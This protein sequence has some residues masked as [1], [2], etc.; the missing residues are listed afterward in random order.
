[1]TTGLRT[2]TADGVLTIRLD[3]AEKRNALTAD[4][5]GGIAEALAQAELDAAVRVVALR[6]EGKDFCAG[7]DLAELL[8][9]AQHSLDEN[10]RDA[11]ALGEV[12]LAMRRLPK[13]VVA[14]VQG[15]AVAGGAG[16][17][18]AADLV[19][20]ARSASFG[21]PEIERGFVPAMVMT[22]LRRSVGEKRAFE[23]VSTGRLV[24]AD[25]ALGLGLVSRVVDD[26]GLEDAARALL[27]QLTARSAT[28]LALTKQLFTDLDGRDVA[29]GILL[30][31]RV[32]ALSR[33]TDDFKR[34]VA[35][36]LDR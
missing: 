8:A 9:S 15:R 29:T 11:L 31:A 14:I 23:L 12:F 3:R 1:M 5:I 26:A 10:E 35:A 4:M 19:V 34:A 18:T 16:L 33:S 13:P 21:Y 22:L 20:A 7:A 36:F 17:A 30:G 6:G 2:S 32:N 24:S 27:A 28:A 25:E